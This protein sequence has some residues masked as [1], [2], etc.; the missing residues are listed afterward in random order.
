MQV[1]TFIVQYPAVP[2]PMIRGKDDDVMRSQHGC[3][4]V[5]VESAS[6]THVPYF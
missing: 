6:V 3:K 4:L 5:S 2:P 1:D